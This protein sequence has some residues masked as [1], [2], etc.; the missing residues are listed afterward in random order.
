MKALNLKAKAKLK[1]RSLTK[2]TRGSEVR[3]HLKRDFDVAA[4]N[5]AWVGDITR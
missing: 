2:A 1:R 5:V 3:D 4:M